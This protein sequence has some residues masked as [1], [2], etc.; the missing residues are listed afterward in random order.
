MG[1]GQRW[2]LRV[3]HRREVGEGAAAR[4]PGPIVLRP[5]AI[6]ESG[7]GPATFDPAIGF[8]YLGRLGAGA[9]EAS[10]DIWTISHEGLSWTSASSTVP[11]PMA[12]TVELNAGILESSVESGPRL[13]AVWTWAPSLVDAIQVQRLSRLWFEALVGICTHVRTGSGRL[14]PSDI[15]P[16]RLT[17]GELD[18]LTKCLRVADVLP[19]TP[20]QQG[21]LFHSAIAARADSAAAGTAL[22]DIYAVQLNLTMTGAVDPRRLYNAMHAVVKRHP[23][24]VARFCTRFGEPVQVIPADPTICW[25]QTEFESTEELER[26][27]AAERV[28]ACDLAGKSTFRSALVR[29]GGDKHR[30]I[31][32]FH[33]VVIDGWSLPILLREIF[34]I[35]FGQALAPA[36]SYRGFVSWLA[37]QDREA[38]RAVWRKALE[39][40]ETP[41][42]VAPRSVPGPRGVASYRISPETTRALG[43]LARSQHTTVSTVLRAAWA[44]LLMVQTGAHDVAFGTVVSG[45]PALLTGADSV[46][47]LLI[48]TVPVRARASATTTVAELLRDMQSIHNDL[49][50]HEHL[51]LNEIHRLTGHDRL[52][53]TLFLYENYPVD[54]STFMGAH[55]LGITE[56]TSRE[57]NH[58]PLSVMALPGHELGIRIEYDTD[59]FDVADIGALVQRLRRILGAMT[60][61]PARRVLSIDVLEVEERGRLDRWGNRAVLAC[62]TAASSSIPEMFAR[63]VDRAPHAVALTFQGRSMTY[64]ELD[65]AANRLAQLLASR[66][67]GRRIDSADGHAPMM[68]S[69]RYWR[70]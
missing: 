6:S 67:A 42:L 66:G 18:E 70:C 48:N 36:P 52:F 3:G 40:F 39:G 22:A 31:L 19:L 51:A 33:H 69:S 26:F 55:E 25:Q 53:D 68:R 41:T 4:P 35:Y 34:A 29:T 56:F 28:A 58:Y 32:T 43:D 45:R 49:L 8:N 16:A 17:Q 64:R 7:S 60:A 54:V 65:H 57:Y 12:H 37:Q 14:T 13:Q 46:V 24:L 61:D 15:L 47:G 50:E 62:A 5:A 27:C 20:V 30:F 21:L 38:A 10:E 44:Q 23:N 63:Q 11:M 2:R 1:A 9:T 59:A